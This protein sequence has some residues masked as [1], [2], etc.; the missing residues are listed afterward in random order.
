MNADVNASVNMLLYA[1]ALLNHEVNQGDS[2]LK[3]TRTVRT[4]PGG[5]L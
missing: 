2:I 4:A 3:V 1:V 5:A